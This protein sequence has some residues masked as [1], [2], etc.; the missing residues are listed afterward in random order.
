MDRNTYRLVNQAQVL[1]Q[2]FPGANSADSVVI[3][4]YDLDD[5]AADVSLAAMTY[6]TGVTWSYSWTPTENHF[7]LVDFY[8][9]TM[10]VHHYEYVKVTGE[11]TGTPGGS[12]V[13]STLAVLR[14]AFLIQLDQWSTTSGN[15]LSGDASLGD[16]ATKCL[17]KALQKIYSLLKSSKYLQAYGSTSLVSTVDQAY[18]ALS[19]ISDLDEVVSVQDSS[20]DYS[21]VYM[22]PYDYF[23]YVPDPAADTGTPTHYTRVFNRIYLNPRPTE[24]IT[25]TTQYQKNYA[26]LSGDSDVAL[27]P[28]KYN[29]WIYA[30]AEVEFYKTL[31]PYNIPSIVLD[32]RNRNREIAMADALS[33]FNEMIVSD[34]HWFR[35][36][37]TPERDYERPVG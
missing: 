18:I 1:A 22:Q 8:N 14:K 37:R 10:D 3:S 31:D 7:Y 25:Y 11:L 21:L 29:Y 6:E 17:N 32:E 36:E 5:N 4:I 13:G 28:S 33:R 12:G 26:D 30:E 35:G 27:I 34:S 2:A 20:N 24:A 15:D 9:Q 16:I 19:A 23:R